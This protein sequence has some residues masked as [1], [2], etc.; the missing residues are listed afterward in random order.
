MTEI[1][2]R[3]ACSAD[4]MVLTDDLGHKGAE[5]VGKGDPFTTERVPKVALDCA[6]LG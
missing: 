2:F 3:L 4:H 5:L 6:G 1:S